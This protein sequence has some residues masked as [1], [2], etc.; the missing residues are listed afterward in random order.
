VDWFGGSLL[1]SQSVKTL[2]T[3]KIVLFFNCHWSN[4]NHLFFKSVQSTLKIFGNS[5]LSLGQQQLKKRVI[6]KLKRAIFIRKCHI[7]ND[8][9][10]NP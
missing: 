1:D 9:L 6:L 4:D 10:R 3:F 2:F 5:K 7:I 8:T